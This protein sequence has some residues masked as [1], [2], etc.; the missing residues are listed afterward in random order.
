MFTIIIA[1]G[2]VTWHTKKQKKMKNN[3]SKSKQHKYT[4]FQFIWSAEPNA[5]AEQIVWT[6]C[7]M[8][9]NFFLFIFLGHTSYVHSTCVCV[10][11]QIICR[12]WSFS[13][14]KICWNLMCVWHCYLRGER[15]SKCVCFFSVASESAIRP[16]DFTFTFIVRM[17]MVWRVDAVRGTR[18]DCDILRRARIEKRT[19]P[20]R[21]SLVPS[22]YWAMYKGNEHTATDKI[23]NCFFLFFSLIHA[24]HFFRVYLIAVCCYY[25]WN[26]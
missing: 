2:P 11:G 6:Y 13:K 24:F 1:Q 8:S 4:S 20:R 17:L 3:S 10:S 26:K 25:Y 16:I 5:N 14:R 9:F 21:N 15:T 22:A 18:Y 19:E 7:L 12:I 23:R